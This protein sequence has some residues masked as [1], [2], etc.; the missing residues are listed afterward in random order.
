MQSFVVAF[1]V[2]V[3]HSTNICCVISP[4]APAPALRFFVFEGAPADPGL[5][6]DVGSSIALRLFPVLAPS[7]T[8]AGGLSALLLLPGVLPATGLVARLL[9]PASGLP[10]RLVPFVFSLGAFGLVA[11]FA[12]TE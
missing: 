10:A 8:S 2:F 12:T 7:E 4:A 6:G 3:S 1:V 5:V 9:A 11:R